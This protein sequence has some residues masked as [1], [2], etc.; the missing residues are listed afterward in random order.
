MIVDTEIV[1][2]LLRIL[3]SFGSC[4]AREDILHIQYNQSAMTVATMAQIREHLQHC[5]DKGWVDYIVDPLDSK[6]RKW[7]ITQDGKVILREA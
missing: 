4:A 7:F 2:N 3:N 6:T 5:K 1:S